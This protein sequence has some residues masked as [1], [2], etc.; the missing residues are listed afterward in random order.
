MKKRDWFKHHEKHEGS[1]HCTTGGAC[2]GSVY[3]LGFIGSLVYYT[4]QANGFWEVIL[5]ILKAMVWPAFLIYKLLNFQ[6]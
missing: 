5:G 3:F 1:C 4:Q 2:G 6:I